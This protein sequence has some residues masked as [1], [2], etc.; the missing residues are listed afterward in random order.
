MGRLGAHGRTV[1]FANT[2]ICMTSNAGSTDKSIGVGFNRTENEISRDKAMKGLREFLRPEFISRIDEIVVFKD[3]TKENFA[4][5]A[6]LMI[7]EMKEPLAEKDITVDYT[8]QALELIAEK[9]FGKPYGARDIRRVIRDEVED[10]VA[11]I[12]LE[13]GSEINKISISCDGDKIIVE[14]SKEAT[15]NEA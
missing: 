15:E 14:G 10:Q 6:A 13:R 2:I 9:S 7:D 3:L 12:S 4:D 11:E 5:I 1:N 8:R